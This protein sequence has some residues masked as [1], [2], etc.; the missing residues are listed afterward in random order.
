MQIFVCPVCKFRGRFNDIERA[1][2]VRLLAQCP[3]CGA[4]ERHRIQYLVLQRIMRGDLNKSK[5]LHFAPEAFF[6]EYFSTRFIQYDTADFE[7]EDVDYKVDIQNLPFKDE[8]YDFIFASH[9]LEHV[10]DGMKALSEIKRILKVDGVAVLP[11]PIVADN[12]IEYP[13]PQEF[14]HVRAPGMDYFDRYQQVF[15]NVKVYYSGD[16]PE[17]YQVH[18]Y[19]DRSVW[20]TA[21]C[22]LR[23]PM[24]GRR[25]SD[26]V[27]VCTR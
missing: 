10:K 15:S 4:L 5:M 3:K 24:T 12:T 21:E 16:F 17:R 9:V 19:E 27:P 20:P 1:A 6:S 26:A 18:I 23:R 25:H 11:V 22:P 14:G 13:E 2:G 7:R 8:S